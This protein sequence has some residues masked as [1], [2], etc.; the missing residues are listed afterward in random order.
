MRAFQS[1]PAARRR[2]TGPRGENTLIAATLGLC[3]ASLAG[4]AHASSALLEEIQSRKPPPLHPNDGGAREARRSRARHGVAH[5]QRPARNPATDDR[6]RD[7]GGE[8]NRVLAQSLFEY[9]P[10][11]AQCND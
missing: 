2:A 3:V 11:A 9:S 10:G 4:G 5:S 6:S 8:A 1:F 7:G